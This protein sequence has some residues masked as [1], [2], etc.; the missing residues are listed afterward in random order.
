MPEPSL[1]A[2]SELDERPAFSMADLEPEADATRVRLHLDMPYGDEGAAGDDDAPADLSDRLDRATFAE[3]FVDAWAVPGLIKEHYKPLAV[4]EDRRPAGVTT[5]GVIYDFIAPR[6]PWLIPPQSALSVELFI[7]A[8][9]VKG[10][11]D[12]LQVI[13]AEQAALRAAA[14]AEANGQAGG[15][16]QG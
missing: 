2:P 14:A 3:M 11:L 10:Q 7:A 9:F 1:A 6:F 13:R 12:T 5:G 15:F 8:A 16:G 4:A